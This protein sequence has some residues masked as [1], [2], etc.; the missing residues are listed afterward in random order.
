MGVE[1]VLV[2]RERDGTLVLVTVNRPKQ[3]NAIGAWPRP[4]GPAD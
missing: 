4:A 1:T 2:E 3:L